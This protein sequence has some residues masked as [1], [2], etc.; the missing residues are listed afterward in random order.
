MMPGTTTS[1]LV[2]ASDNN[3]GAVYVYSISVDGLTLVGTLTGFAYPSGLCADKKGDVWVVDSRSQS[4]FKPNLYEF[5]HGGTKAIATL[6]DEHAVP[7]GCAVDPMTGN[8]AVANL[9]ATSSIKE[10]QGNVAVFKHAA[11][12]PMLYYP[13]PF[14]TGFYG[15]FCGYDDAGNLFVDFQ[16]SY[17]GQSFG[18][19]ELAKGASQIKVIALRG[20][21]INSPGQ[22]QWDG[23]HVTVTDPNANPTTNSNTTVIYRTTGAGGQIVSSMDLDSANIVEPWIA[24][25]MVYGNLVVAPNAARRKLQLYVY[26]RG[27]GMIWQELQTHRLFGTTVSLASS[28]AGRRALEFR[29]SAQPFR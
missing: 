9:N 21:A 22:V 19:G 28:S 2:Y 29:P 10:A 24:Q 6:T 12:K 13:P 27:N 16:T 8:L 25:F 17:L 1:D 18:F 14:S 3:S 11:G 7:I 20:G 26:H 5:A 4:S 23:Q 15:E